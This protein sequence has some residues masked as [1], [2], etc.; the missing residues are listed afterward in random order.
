MFPLELPPQPPWEGLHPLVIHFPI[1][2]LFVTPVFVVLAGLL[3]RPGRWFG[4]TALILLVMGT[5]SGY[6]AV[7]TGDAAF[8]VL[9]EIDDDGWEVVEEHQDAAKKV[10]SLFVGLTVLYAVILALPLVI[11]KLNAWLYWFI[12]NLVFLALLMVVNIQLANAAHL[13]GRLVHQYGARAVLGEPAEES[14]P[15]EEATDE[16]ME[17]PTEESA[18]E[19]AVEPMEEP[20]SESTDPTSES[21]E[22]PADEP[23]DE[24]EPAP[25][26][27]PKTEAETEEAEKV[28]AEKAAT[29]EEPAKE[30]PVE[31]ESETDETEAA[32]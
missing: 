18:D 23:M 27:S 13:G 19:P 28:P 32:G 7:Q 16:T 22:L 8:D 20:A 4:L 17:E 10:Q 15:E 6:V 24:T 14:E 2:L 9:E 30:E 26:E 1:A 29:E 31:S 5:V 25:A 3:G 12:A 11:W 21:T